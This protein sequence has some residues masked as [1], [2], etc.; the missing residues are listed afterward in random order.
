MNDNNN[1][2]ENSGKIKFRE[3]LNVLLIIRMPI[4]ILTDEMMGC[5]GSVSFE[6][7]IAALRCV[8]DSRRCTVSL[9]I[10]DYDVWSPHHYFSMQ[11][12]R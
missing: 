12:T 2:N 8:C 5:M 4:N 6:R 3:L 11:R 7:K 10:S 1:N 9:V